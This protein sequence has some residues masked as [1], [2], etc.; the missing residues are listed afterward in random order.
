MEKVESR[1][2]PLEEAA[3]TAIAFAANMLSARLLSSEQFNVVLDSIVRLRQDGQLDSLQILIS[4]LQGELKVK[5]LNGPSVGIGG[6]MVYKDDS[7]GFAYTA[8]MMSDIASNSPDSFGDL[9]NHLRAAS[10]KQGYALVPKK[11]RGKGKRFAAKYYAQVL[12]EH[13]I[14]IIDGASMISLPPREETFVY[15]GVEFAFPSQFPN[16]AAPMSKWVLPKYMNN[17]YVVGF[18]VEVMNSIKRLASERPELANDLIGT[19][20]RLSEVINTHYYGNGS[21]EG[22]A[23]RLAAVLAVANRVRKAP[24]W[25]VPKKKWKARTFNTYKEAERV[26]LKYMPCDN[27]SNVIQLNTSNVAELINRGLEKEGAPFHSINAKSDPGLAYGPGVSRAQVWTQDRLLATLILRSL[28]NSGKVDFW[29]EWGWL[30]L[31]EIKAKG[32]VY[33]REQYVTKTRNIFVTEAAAFLPAHLIVHNITVGQRNYLSDIPAPNLYGV[34]FTHGGMDLL[35]RK[36]LKVPT[37]TRQFIVFSD[38]LYLVDNTTGVLQ[39]C[40]LD[41]EKMEGNVDPKDVE[42]LYEYWWR[43]YFKYEYNPKQPPIPGIRFTGSS[44]ISEEETK[45]LWYRYCTEVVPTL[46]ADAIGV[47]GAAQVKIMGLVSGAV[48]TGPVN[49]VKSAGAADAMDQLP[50]RLVE[51]GKFTAEARKAFQATCVSLTVEL[52]HQDLRQ[53]VQDVYSLDDAIA[54][55]YPP[56]KMIGLTVMD[57]LGFDMVHLGFGKTRVFLPVLALPRFEKAM[58]FN[59]KYFDEEGEPKIWSGGSAKSG[60]EAASLNALAVIQLSKYRTLYMIGGWYYH[61]YGMLLQRLIQDRF[62]FLMESVSDIGQ[63][64]IIMNDANQTTIWNEAVPLSTFTVGDVIKTAAV[65]TLFEVVEFLADQNATQE[66]LDWV[67]NE[68]IELAPRLVPYYIAREVAELSGEL[69]MYPVDERDVASITVVSEER[70]Q[71]PDQDLPIPDQP[72]VTNWQAD[73]FAILNQ[74]KKKPAK[75]KERS[76]TTD[77]WRGVVAKPQVLYPAEEIPDYLLTQLRRLW[78]PEY[79][80]RYLELVALPETYERAET[81]NPQAAAFAIF[82]RKLAGSLMDR[83]TDKPYSLA[84]IVAGIQFYQ[85]KYPGKLTFGFEAPPGAIIIEKRGVMGTR[86]RVKHY[87]DE[88]GGISSDAIVILKRQ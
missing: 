28:Y 66:F 74:G 16:I 63:L 41:G 34:D 88:N 85:K 40:S 44:E 46:T 80:F 65:P 45:H 87:R 23:G 58:V 73:T 47:F 20:N 86:G 82:A 60:M 50:G 5:N 54:G 42:M 24:E 3:A 13:S 68:H 25:F 37:G 55:Y 15:E 21:P 43:N 79:S 10:A 29:N 49:G 39:Y 77:P 33:T 9:R 64:S 75:L 52:E 56:G 2:G 4:R 7:T 30:R 1:I 69:G 84:E 12:K 6:L 78:P 36:F 81:K 70:P 8:Q 83:R 26:L 17:Y 51:D 61:P 53:E 38:N 72:G 48:A 62:N 18:S 71:N 11:F 59:K 35:V 57:M 14:K 67:I 19:Y 76:A 32:E 27:R 22:Q 31:V